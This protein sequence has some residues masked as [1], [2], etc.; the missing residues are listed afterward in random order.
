[1]I[2]S[3]WVEE[4]QVSLLLKSCI[5]CIKLIEYIQIH[6][7]IVTYKRHRKTHTKRKPLLVKIEG[8]ILFITS[9]F[10]VQSI[11]C[12]HWAEVDE[13]EFFL[14][15]IPDNNHGRNER[16][17]ESLFCIPS[18]SLPFSWQEPEVEGRWEMS[19]GGDW[20]SQCCSIDGSQ[21]HPKCDTHTLGT[22]SGAGRARH[23]NLGLSCL[24]SC[25]WI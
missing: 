20:C 23:H 9:F 14:Q 4:Q 5:I 13:K 17:R 11:S 16:I 2:Q 25:I 22:S 1:M 21:H 19:W 10:L 3:W 7:C 15:R 6:E 24:T 8:A 18:Q 12:K